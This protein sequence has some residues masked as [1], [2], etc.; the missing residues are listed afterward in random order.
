MDV[1]IADSSPVLRRRFVRMAVE[2]LGDIR[3]SEAENYD[4]LRAL[5]SRY[6]PQLIFV[7]IFLPG[8]GALKLLDDIRETRGSTNVVVLMNT[9]D[10]SLEQYSIDKG[11][12][13]VYLKDDDLV[14]AMSI[15]TIV[16]P[17]RAKRALVNEGRV[18]RTQFNERR[19]L[20]SV[21]HNLCQS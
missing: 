10:E 8:G 3:I 13:S 7:D 16:I 19:V 14:K 21:E 2:I 5:Y 17:F 15:H 11:A 1:L 12:L 9:K 20:S 18:P 6:I 4:E